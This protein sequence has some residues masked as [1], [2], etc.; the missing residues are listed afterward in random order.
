M[1]LRASSKSSSRPLALTPHPPSRPWPLS[2]AL[3]A[4]LPALLLA[5]PPAPAHGALWLSEILADPARDW[6]GSGAVDS[7]DDEWI[8]IY[9]S[10]PDA[11]ELAGYYVRD[12][13]GTEAHLRLSGR[14]AAGEAAVF[15]G[16][17]AAAWQ[18][19]QGL[20]VTGLSL[21]NAG[22]TVHLYLG[23]PAQAGAQLVD[24]YIYADHEAEDDRASGRLR[25]DGEW[26][27]F[28]GLYPYTGSLMPPATGCEPSPG[29]PNPCQG[30]VPATELSWGQVKD[31]YR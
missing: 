29:V 13:L 24:V 30:L 28:D 21:N 3:L 22:D 10:G 27:L 11:V 16:S 4:A 14:L 23:D 6:N 25:G 2:L 15:Y 5:L 17:D 12:A 31:H 19:A 7:R 8:E 20:S 9:N 1:I 26:A 18:A